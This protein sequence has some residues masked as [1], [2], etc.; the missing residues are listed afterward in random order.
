MENRLKERLTG[1]AILV[2]LIVLIVPE[3]FRGQSTAPRAAHAPQAP[4]GAPVRSYTID[5]NAAGAQAAPPQ[6]A[7]PAAGPAAAPAAAPV[8]SPVASPVETRVKAP[9]VAAVKARGKAPAR[10]SPAAHQRSAAAAGAARGAAAAVHAA[11]AG[12]AGWSVQL[13]LFS[14]ADNATRLARTAHG[15]GFAVHVSRSARGLYRVAL[16]GLS[17]RAAALRASRR[18]KAAGLPAAIMGPR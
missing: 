1:A 5:L 6:V 9:A 17:D 4:E 3:V 2:A 10:P 12:E 8:A 15:K 13:G 7:P 16:V 14:K 18:L 11:T